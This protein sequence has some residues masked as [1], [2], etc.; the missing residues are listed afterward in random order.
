MKSYGS[1]HDHVDDYL[2]TPIYYAI[3][4]NRQDV[5]EWLLE[6]GVD[7]NIIDRRSQGLVNFAMRHNRQQMKEQLIKAGAKNTL[8]K[9]AKQPASKKPVPVPQQKQRVNERLQP[10][11]YVLQVFDGV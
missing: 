1:E 5:F 4:S 2:Q 10:K 6:Q 8:L 11:K 9:D 3:K 7:L